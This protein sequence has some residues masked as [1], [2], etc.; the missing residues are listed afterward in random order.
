MLC[1]PSWCSVNSRNRNDS[2]PLAELPQE[3]ISKNVLVT[4][5]LEKSFKFQSREEWQKISK[6]QF[7]HCGKQVVY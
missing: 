5:A 4:L 6:D 3:R 7:Q 2:I 1:P